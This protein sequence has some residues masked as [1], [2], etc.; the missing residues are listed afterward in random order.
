M[1][2]RAHGFADALERRDGRERRTRPRLELENVARAAVDARARDLS[3][4]HRGHDGVDRLRRI[5][6][7]EKILRA[8]F[9]RDHTALLRRVAFAAAYHGHRIC[10]RDA[11][12]AEG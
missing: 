1:F 8:R 5:R 4:L 11:T 3:P 6:R 2:W 9:H 10:D 12:E 7:L